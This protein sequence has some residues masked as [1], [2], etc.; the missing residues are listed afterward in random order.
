MNAPET[1]RMALDAHHRE[2][3]EEIRLH[4]AEAVKLTVNGKIDKLSEQVKM[5][6]ERA[7]VAARTGQESAERLVML[8]EQLKPIA[9][10]YDDLAGTKKVLR[11]L[12]YTVSLGVGFAI[13]IKAL[14]K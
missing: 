5:A 13:S 9:E 12:F 8:E 1:R 11:F 6:S 10:I 2:L 3:V 7:E 4:V 14:L